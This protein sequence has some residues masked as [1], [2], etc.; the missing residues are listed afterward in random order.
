MLTPSRGR[1]GGIERYAETLEW[2]LDRQSVQYQRLDLDQPGVS[3]HR[4]LVAQSRALIRDAGEPTR[5][6]VLHRALLPAAALLARDP[7]VSGISVVCH[8]SDVWAGR[9]SPRSQVE[10]L[11]M[12]QSGVRVVAVS[13]FTS[14]ALSRRCPTS[15]LPPGLSE[16]W[17][18][19]LVNASAQL[20]E[21]RLDIH[22]VTAFRMSD[23]RQKGL[24]ELLEAVAALGRADVLLTVCGT[25]EP[26]PDLQRLVRRY[27][28]CTLRSGLDDAGLAHELADADLF[29]LATRT[30]CGRRPSGEGFGLVLLEAQV[31]GTP[32]V[33]PAFG[34]SHDAFVD[35][36]TGLAP[37]DETA[38]ALAAALA[39]MLRDRARLELMGKNAAEWARNCFLPQRYATW[40]V[41]RLLPE[42]DDIPPGHYEIGDGN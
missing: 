39:E 12:R 31:A 6:V 18:D 15:V 16:Q 37:A 25:G 21:P 29:V 19:T 17:F 3:A 27:G 8:G 7:E 42:I 40:A 32:V 11:L 9:L 38:G 14:G 24:P 33:G 4:R 20:R 41:A 30:K 34:G 28:W 2:A 36:H 5:L 22:L 35:R 26:P 1:G 10:Y 23:W 13:S